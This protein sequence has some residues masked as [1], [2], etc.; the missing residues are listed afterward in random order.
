MK[1][2]GL[3]GGLGPAATVLY[4]QALV[5]EA[6][7][8]GEVLRLLVNHAEVGK[9]LDLAARDARDELGDYLLRLMLELDSGGAEV[10]AVS[11]V[12]P[13]LGAEFLRAAY[14]D[15]FIDI[16]DVIN[17]RLG[18]VGARRAILL[19]TR[20][21]MQSR[22]FGRLS[23]EPA[24]LSE[25]EL[26][27]AHGLYV[28]IV[29]AQAAAPETT[30]TLTAMART[31]LQREGADAIVLAGSELSLIEPGAWG[32]LP[33]IDAGRLHVEAILDVATA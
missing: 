30:A 19:G 23:C 24:T 18:E 22:L 27:Q 29:Q 20:R 6:G 25:A 12:T 9:V 21:V 8:R 17:E 26:D 1:L 5:A 15:R 14:G 3:I 7:R 4:Y 11:A 13:H 28:S 33:V 2:I 32:E 10:L 31:L 16:V